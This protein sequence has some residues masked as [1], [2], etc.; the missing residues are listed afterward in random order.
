MHAAYASMD[1]A[2]D[3]LSSYGI[4]LTNGNSNHAPM[5]AEA[6]CAL[7]RPAAVM[8]WIARYRERMLPRP[9]R[10]ETI[11]R[12]NWRDAIGRRD[13]FSDWALFFAAE[14]KEA[15][16]AE[17][18]DRWAARLA[19]GFA[20][21]A[22]H[23]VIRVGHAARSLAAAE[24][25]ARLRELADALG[26]W[27]ATYR[28]LPFGDCPTN[29]ALTPREAITQVPIIAPER[30]RNLGNITASLAML[31]DFREFAPVKGLIDIGSDV[32]RLLV[33]LTEVF[34]GIYIANARDRLTAIVFIHG[35]TSLAA[36]GNISSAVSPTTLRALL[37]FAWQTACG[38]YSC[39]GH[40]ATIIDQAEPEERDTAV[41]VDRAVANGDEHVIKFTE[42]CLRQ[43][44]L[45]PSP[46]YIAAIDSVLTLLSSR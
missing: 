20:A 25:S 12:D 32:D 13:R 19:P 10:R 15:P 35:V 38:L 23:G 21:A 2:L 5:V 16:W 39:Y 33:E 7:G 37:P 18:L 22:T 29:G 43:H 27:A 36:L 3:A 14:L 44:A 9:P 26:S 40:G 28:E 8:P 42:A 31:D 17:V 24:T 11:S 41:L 6:L 46:H 45:A 34:A 4:E 30:R 1:E